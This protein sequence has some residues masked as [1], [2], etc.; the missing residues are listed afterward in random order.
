MKKIHIIANRREYI[1]C[2]KFKSERYK[3]LPVH[4]PL[5][6]QTFPGSHVP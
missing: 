3:D 4:M 5:G 2:Q 1:E 6:A